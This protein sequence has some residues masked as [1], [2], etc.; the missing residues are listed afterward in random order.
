MSKKSVF[1]PSAQR[2]GSKREMTE[3]YWKKDNW[4]KAE[5]VGFSMSNGKA[6]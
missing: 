5:N 3:I 2:E 6:R 4:E 1:L